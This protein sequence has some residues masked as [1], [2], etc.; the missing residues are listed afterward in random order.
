MESTKHPDQNPELNQEENSQQEVPVSTV[1][2]MPMQAAVETEQAIA[3]AIA[4]VAPAAETQEIQVEAEIETQAGPVAETETQ[5]VAVA[6]AEQLFV[7]VTVTVYVPAVETVIVCVASFVLHKY[8]DPAFPASSTVEL[9][10][11]KP[12]LPP[13]S[14]TGSG[15]I[16][17]TTV[18]YPEQLYAFVTITE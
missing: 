7:F 1:N 5:A 12:T 3:E 14:T 11:Q 13:R 17:T 6:E 16:T 10:T 15:L 9:P 4:E 2:E 8:E 18:S